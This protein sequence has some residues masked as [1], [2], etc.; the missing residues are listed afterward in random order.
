MKTTINRTE[1]KK[2]FDIACETWQPRIEKYAQRNPFGDNIDFSEKEINGKPLQAQMIVCWNRALNEKHEFKEKDEK[3]RIWWNL[4]PF[5][6][7][8]S[9]WHRSHAFVPLAFCFKNETLLKEAV[10][11]F[12]E[13]YKLSRTTL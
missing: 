7:D 8:V 5:G 9:N 4:Y 1:L 2:I 13:E 10:K 3:W 11:E 12:E 6:F